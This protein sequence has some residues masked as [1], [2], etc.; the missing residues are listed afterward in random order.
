MYA[1]FHITFILGAI[2]TVYS[3]NPPYRESTVSINTKKWL[4]TVSDKFV[5][6]SVDPLVLIKSENY[7]K[8]ALNMAKTLSPAYLRVGGPGSDNFSFQSKSDELDFMSN[9]TVT[10]SEW[11]LLNELLED[12]GLNLIICLNGITRVDG[13][14]DSRNTLQLVSFS[15]RRGYNMDFELGY[16]SQ[17][18]VA[19]GGTSPGAEMGRDIVRLRKILD[20]YPRYTPSMIIGPD[21]TRLVKSEDVAFARN[22]LHEAGNSLSALTLHPRFSSSLKAEEDPSMEMLQMIA[23]LETNV[24]G[25][26]MLARLSGKAPPRKPIWIA[27]SRTKEAPPQFKDAINWLR[28]LGAAAK[29]G[30]QVMMSQPHPS[31]F[32]NP[33]PDFWMM[34][35]HKALVGRQVLDSKLISGNKT[36]I[37]A[38]SH[39]TQ[40]VHNPDTT[41]LDDTLVKYEKG[42]VTLFG[43]NM[44]DEKIRLNLKVNIKEEEI[45]KYIL[46]EG[47]DPATG[48]RITLFNNQKLTL[49][50]DGEIPILTPKIRKP[51]RSLALTL[52][53]KSIFF[54]VIPDIK[55]RTCMLPLSAFL[56]DTA[57]AQ[58]KAPVQEDVIESVSVE[59]KRPASEESTESNEVFVS[60][61]SPMFADKS[62]S[63]MLSHKDKFGKS[64]KKSSDPKAEPEPIVKYITFSDNNWLSDFPKKIDVAAAKEE[65]DDSLMA[66]E[67]P[68][69]ASFIPYGHT[70]EAETPASRR[71]KYKIFTDAVFGRR[72]ISSSDS[73]YTDANNLARSRPARHIDLKAKEEARENS[74]RK[75][76]KLS[77]SMSKLGQFLDENRIHHIRKERIQKTHADSPIFEELESQEAVP[78]STLKSEGL[79]RLNTIDTKHKV[80]PEH[81]R[82]PRGLSLQDEFFMK[83]LLDLDLYERMEDDQKPEGSRNKREI[84]QSGKSNSN[85]LKS[86]Y[87]E[88]KDNI[89]RIIR[90]ERGSKVNGGRPKRALSDEQKAKL[91]SYLSEVREKYAVAAAAAKNK[92]GE[93]V[94][95]G[96]PEKVSFARVEKLSYARGGAKEEKVGRARGEPKEERVGRARVPPREER[97][98]YARRQQE[99]K[100]SYAKDSAKE[101]KTPKEDN[102]GSTYDA[103]K[104]EK[105]ATLEERI[106]AAREAALEEKLTREAAREEKLNSIREAKEDKL[107]HPK[108]G[109][110]EEKP[111]EAPKEEKVGKSSTK[112]EKVGYAR[113]APKEERLSY[114]RRVGAEEK[115]GST[116]QP[117]KEEKVA[118]GKDAKEDKV[119]RPRVG[120]TKEE[121]KDESEEP[122]V[123]PI[124]SRHGVEGTLGEIA[125]ISREKIMQAVKEKAENLISSMRNKEA[126]QSV[127]AKEAKEETP[128]TKVEDKPAKS[129]PAVG[130]S[131]KESE[132]SSKEESATGTAE[133]TGSPRVRSSRVRAQTPK[134]GDEKETE[135]KDGEANKVGKEREPKVGKERES[136]VGKER[137]SKVGKERESKVGKERES[138]VGKEKESKA[139]KEDDE[140]TET[141]KVG[142]QH[143]KV[144]SEREDKSEH[145]KEKSESVAS[146]KST[147]AAAEAQPATSNSEQPAE[148]AKPSRLGKSRRAKRE[149]NSFQHSF[150]YPYT[151]KNYADYA[152]YIKKGAV[153][154]ME[155]SVYD[156]PKMIDRD[157]VWRTNMPSKLHQIYPGYY[158]QGAPSKTENARS[159]HSETFRNTVSKVPVASS[160][161]SESYE[162]SPEVP[163]NH[164]MSNKLYS[165]K[166]SQKPGKTVV[167]QVF[168][169]SGKKIANEVYSSLHDYLYP[170]N[171]NK[172]LAQNL[173]RP[174]ISN[175]D[176]LQTLDSKSIDDPSVELTA[177]DS[178]ENFASDADR[179]IKE[180]VNAMNKIMAGDLADAKAATV[181]STE[182][183]DFSRASESAGSSSESSEQY[184]ES[185]VCV[186]DES[187]ESDAQL[188]APH[189]VTSTTPQ[190]PKSAF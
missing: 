62:L 141:E 54:V 147:V 21:L 131:K 135:K 44:A 154:R 113:G 182:N 171:Y 129:E 107:G 6:L 134:A 188:Q 137:E 125:Q 72:N 12:A 128:E 101:E 42:A 123:S 4:H 132:K 109:E 34:T 146:E 185:S 96:K 51:N 111:T 176:Y 58:A 59:E 121:E 122:I 160:F 186:N 36:M 149:M 71:E 164:K 2:C 175:D 47:K 37:E 138:K 183:R 22:Y 11:V 179:S 7:G 79:K 85:A 69:P 30:V 172:Y 17:W 105:E 106:S 55:A 10:A 170:V 97:V 75:T 63:K 115:I 60:F 120:S 20:S 52:P 126:A 77:D 28:R 144:G 46:T 166:P 155:S 84:A 165:N 178:T 53:A 8:A 145:E 32:T 189:D 31:S 157:P 43:V 57:Q 74:V 78:V 133:R 151:V 16:E 24:W 87:D 103:P 136:K 127:G 117:A 169:E 163:Y 168:D 152:E 143:Y 39:C 82:K 93:K 38:Y 35:L 26:D 15:D 139:G 94:S 88:S 116:G 184:D 89:L 119:S 83:L 66:V 13:V 25:K 159:I 90:E 9:T 140:K 48:E 50:P 45:H 174:S 41:I 167:V 80:E 124:K 153:E 76:P 27:E 29:L 5:S 158:V 18:T 19:E 81:K 49:S 98:G 3:Y 110:Q 148:T 33:T 61:R 65:D 162:A 99:E 108:D 67:E 14:W 102:L 56:E 181:Y 177:D 40:T 95:R 180:L 1:G 91:E 173:P 23:Q 114:A 161:Q 130:A 104:E 64:T 73:S 190:F 86:T 150:R 118:S 187:N 92:S 142:S 156:A 68:V 100:V 70:L 112:G